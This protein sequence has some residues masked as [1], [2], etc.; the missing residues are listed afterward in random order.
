MDGRIHR[1]IE[2]ICSDNGFAVQITQQTPIVEDR[3][4]KMQVEEKENT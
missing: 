2:N 3:E 4:I 1:I